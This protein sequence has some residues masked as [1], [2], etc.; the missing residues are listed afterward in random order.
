MDRRAFIARLGLAAVYSQLPPILSS[1]SSS[2]D[3]GSNPSRIA[4]ALR[5]PITISGA[6]TLSA[7]NGTAALWPGITSS[8]ILTNNTFLGP[9]IA[10]SKGETLNVRFNNLLSEDSN[11]HWHGLSTPA[12]MDGH[13]KYPVKPGESFDYSFP[14]LD[15][16]GIYWYHA[17]PDR[18]TARQAYMGF[19]GAIIVHDPEEQALSLPSGKFDVPLII[20]DKRLT[21]TGQLVYSPLK[22]D[23]LSG[24]LGDTP[25]INGTPNAFLDVEKTLYRFRLIN[26]SNARL[27]RIAF[28]DSRVMNLIGNDGG[29][30]DKPV[31]LT[32]FYLSPGERAEILVDF[33][34]DTISSSVKL[35]SLTFPFPS[36]HNS[37]EYPQGM[38]MDL[39]EFRIVKDNTI[40][41]AIPSS[42]IA[43]TPLPVASAVQTRKFVLTM[44]HS[45]TY[46]MHL[47]DGKVFEMDRV[48]YRIPINDIE[49]WEI[50]NQGES[51]HGMHIH[52]TQFQVLERLY[53]DWQIQPTD[54]SWKDT[55]FI[56]ANETVRIILQFTAYKGTYLFHCHNLEHEDDGMMVNIEVV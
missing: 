41:P 38:T 54:K 14:V 24:Y 12:V 30:L 47:I 34:A 1:C 31:A 55:V 19:A 10:I 52:G 45:R 53:G 9:T 16:A 11:I 48:D 42:L 13:P 4:Q 51:I 25:F 8:A 33:S 40:Q 46:G 35:Q 7:S 6:G 28:S 44:D 29:L 43:F 5:I 36:S 27:Y 39:M 23:F 50:E 49:I 3:L 21:S 26:A 22:E 17:H 32:S 56:G 37:T 20:Q 15:R 18:A 2:G